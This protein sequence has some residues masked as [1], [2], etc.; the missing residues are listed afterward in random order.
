MQL[1]VGVVTA[2]IIE[3]GEIGDDQGIGSERHPA[4][5]RLLPPGVR[6]RVGEGVDG[7]VQLA[8]VLV[9]VIHRPFQLAVGEVETGKVAGIGVVLEADIDRIGPVI[10]GRFQCRQ[11]ACRTE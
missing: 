4:I 11:A 10:H 6:S 9:Y 8:A 3:H 2:G 1:H 7:D 5:H